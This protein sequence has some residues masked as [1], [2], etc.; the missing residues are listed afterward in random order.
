MSVC[1][2]P[3]CNRRAIHAIVIVLA[4]SMDLPTR[5]GARLAQGFLETT[6]ITMVAEDGHA[7]AATVHDMTHGSGMLNSQLAR[8]SRGRI[9][10]WLVLAMGIG[11]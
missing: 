11:Q 2:L 8:H 9:A 6:T 1:T 10:N 7:P 4:V 3:I 5:L